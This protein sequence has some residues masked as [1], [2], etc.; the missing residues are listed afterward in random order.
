MHK[1][2]ELAISF[3]FTIIHSLFQVKKHLSLLWLDT[4]IHY[5]SKYLN[6]KL[7]NK[8]KE[9]KIMKYKLIYPKLKAP[10]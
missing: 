1:V 10:T 3:L 4:L 5:L 7:R 2:V 6:S 9:N 8:D